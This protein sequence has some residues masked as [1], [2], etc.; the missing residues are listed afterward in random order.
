MTITTKGLVGG[1]TLR[2]IAGMTDPVG[3]LSV[4]VTAD[5][6]EAGAW[7]IRAVDEIVALEHRLR[8]AG[9]DVRADLLALRVADVRPELTALL[10]AAT[11]G[12][13]RGL[14]VPL[15]GG[16]PH[17]IAMQV[18][19]GNC[20]ELAGSAAVRPLATVYSAYPPAGVA[21]VCGHGVRL[22]DVRFGHAADIGE[23]G[24]E[25]ADT[26]DHDHTAPAVTGAGLARHGTAQH[27]L[28]ARHAADRLARFLRRAAGR[29]AARAVDLGWRY[30]VI[31][32]DPE[33]T[34]ALRD[35]LPPAFPVETMTVSQRLAG[36]PAARVHAAVA[37]DLDACR[38]RDVRRLAERAR[39]AAFSGGA[40]AYGLADT[41][42][43]LAEGRV[44]HLL[45]D[46]EGEWTGRSGPDGRLY[47]DLVGVP[48]TAESD[49][50]AEPNLG[51]RMVTAAVRQNAAV[52]MIDPADT[53]PLI[54][55]A[56]VAAL[57]R[58]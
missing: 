37:G 56:G 26:R 7:R 34:A 54:D 19:L 13:G 32:G 17:T 21:V 3:V 35:G 53:D 18:P 44:A 31:T 27:D 14:F 1:T 11:A 39:A 8:H 2:A 24:Y 28:N 16:V 57:L 23:D 48:G 5:P 30:L 33:K 41:L 15:S 52:T 49:L 47:P 46:G 9:D 50:R 20:V 51:E 38:H 12:R 25:R 6:R 58:W 36:L 4:Y 55:G 43:A 42:S 29:V 22:V 10:D 45:L 40:G